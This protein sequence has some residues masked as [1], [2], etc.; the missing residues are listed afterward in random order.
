MVGARSDGIII[1]GVPRSGTTLLRRLLNWHPDVH[2]GGETFLL[3]SAARFLRSDR[4]VDG[5]DYGVIGGLRSAGI[6]P[7]TLLGDLRGFVEGYFRQLAGA[8]GKRRWASKTA[9][10]SFYV[11][12]IEQLFAGHAQFVCIVRHGLDSVLSLKELC[13]ANETY[14]RELHEY[15]VRYPSPFEAFA[16]LWSGV[17]EALLDFA[18]RHAGSTIVLRYEDLVRQP[19]ETLDRLTGFLELAP[20]QALLDALLQDAPSGLGDWK[21]YGKT[22]VDPD[23]IGR[24]HSL[25]PA[26]LFRLAPIVNPVLQR[27]GYDAVDPGPAP[28]AGQAIRRYEK[29]MSVQA[30]RSRSRQKERG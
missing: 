17:T 19:D 28:D 14:I 26:T 20:G 9:I 3:T 11:A 7:E 16:R 12:E 18:G 1:L 6:A 25:S 29:V 2:C 27:A 23:S 30:L 8:A 24:W 15:I 10:D 21:S 4:I 13:D 5:I 22:G